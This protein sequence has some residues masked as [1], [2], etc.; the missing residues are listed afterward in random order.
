MLAHRLKQIEN[1]QIIPG[2]RDEDGSLQCEGTVI[3][4][5]FKK[6][7][8]KLYS[9]GK[10]DLNKEE[11]AKFLEGLTLPTIGSDDRTSMDAPITQREIETVII[12]M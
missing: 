5:S 2:I 1:R 10:N 3:N 12:G 4:D 6:Y 9:S 11:V 8:S 7:Y